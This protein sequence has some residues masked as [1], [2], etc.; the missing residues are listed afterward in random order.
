MKRPAGVSTLLT[1][2]RLTCVPWE[3]IPFFESRPLLAGAHSTAKH[4]GSQKYSL[5]C[6][7]CENVSIVKMLEIP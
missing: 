4:A 1:F 7:K 2:C 5:P 6:K 3:K